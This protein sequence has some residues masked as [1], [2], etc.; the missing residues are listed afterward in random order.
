MDRWKVSE[1]RDKAS[2][3]TLSWYDRIEES[4]TRYIE[5]KPEIVEVSFNTT[6]EAYRICYVTIRLYP[7]CEVEIAY[8]YSED[9]YEFTQTGSF[10]DYNAHDNTIEWIERFREMGY[11]KLEALLHDLRSRIRHRTIDWRRCGLA[12]YFSSLQF[13]VNEEDL[14]SGDM[15]FVAH[16]EGLGYSLLPET[17]CLEVEHPDHLDRGLDEFERML[18]R[19]AE[20]RDLLDRLGADGY[21]EQIAL[22]TLQVHGDP[23]EDIRAIC[24]GYSARYRGMLV[25]REGVNI[26]AAGCLAPPTYIEFRQDHIWVENLSLPETMRLNCQGKPIR[27]LVEMPYLSDTIRILSAEPEQKCEFRGTRIRFKQPK[28]PYCGDSGRYWDRSDE[29]VYGKP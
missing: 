17:P 20:E 5:Q 1:G 25:Y 18:K 4:L 21:I 19:R 16:I 27:S 23:V 11:D 10:D 29:Q 9:V 8:G 13:K 28:F 24:R 12:A 14:M 15:P 6:G 2:Q 3:L 22:N 7:G 26:R